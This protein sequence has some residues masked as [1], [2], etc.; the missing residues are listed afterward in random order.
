MDAKPRLLIGLDNARLGVAKS[1]IGCSP[2]GPIAVKTS[3]GWILY[4]PSVSNKSHGASLGH[5][6]FAR[7]SYIM[8][9]YKKNTMKLVSYGTQ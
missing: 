1:W 7:S 2:S 4:G 9:I 8:R 6:C 5:V 3:L